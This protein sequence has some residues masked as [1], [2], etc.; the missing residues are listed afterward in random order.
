MKVEGILK[1]KG[2]RVETI[3]PE[4]SIMVAVHK[5]TSQGFG[6]L[7]VSTDGKQVEGILSERDIAR[8]LARHGVRLVDRI[9]ADV[10]SR[11]FPTCSPSD[12]ITAV[13]AVMTRTRNRHVPVVEGGTLC[14]LVSIGDLVKSRLDEMELEASILREAYIVGR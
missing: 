11:T 10:M 12:S 3:L 1:A 4:V 14:G 2:S 9:V 7:V 13:M 8:A 5:L 6:A